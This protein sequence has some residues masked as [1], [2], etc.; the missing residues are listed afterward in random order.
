[1]SIKLRSLTVLLAL[2][3]AAGACGGDDG[4]S[5]E[6]KETYMNDCT[7]GLNQE[8][9]QCTLDELEKTFTESELVDLMAES[10]TP[11]PEFDAVVAACIGLLEIDQ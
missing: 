8:F 3:L 11:P 5:N 7:A 6:V 2:A 10:E 9:C 1:M 4:F